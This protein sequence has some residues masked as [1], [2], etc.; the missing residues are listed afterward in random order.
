MFNNV[1]GCSPADKFIVFMIRYEGYSKHV[2]KQLY[3]SL[4]FV[5][6]IRVTLQYVNKPMRVSPG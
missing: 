1:D 5:K 4:G 2:N 3:I 6:K